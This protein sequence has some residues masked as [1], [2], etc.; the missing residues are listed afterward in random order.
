M[1]VEFRIRNFL[2]FKELQVL[3]LGRPDG[4]GGYDFRKTAFIYGANGS[5]KSNI[6]KA[7]D[8]SRRYIIGETEM[9]DYRF[10][11]DKGVVNTEPSYF[12]Y[13]IKLGD[14]VYSF[15]FE[16]DFHSYNIKSEWLYL[17]GE[18]DKC[19][20]EYEIDDTDDYA[21]YDT[22][23]NSKNKDRESQF[24]FIKNWFQEYMIVDANN[25]F[26]LCV[27]VTDNY[28]EDME[29]LLKSLDTGIT[30]I[31]KVAFKNKTIPYNL[32]WGMNLYKGNNL[33]RIEGNERKRDWL[34]FI[35]INGGK[36]EYSELCFKH[37]LEYLA[38]IDETS[39]GT[40]WIFH[41][42]TLFHSYGF[43]QDGLIVLDEIECSI[44]T[45][46]TQALVKLFKN[47]DDSV[48]MIATTHE[49]KLLEHELADV[50]DVWF[51]NKNRRESTLYSL[52]S[53]GDV[54][55]DYGKMYLDGRFYAV[56][57]LN[58]DTE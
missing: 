37:G 39:L 22:I 38:R 20:Y 7:L 45:M 17:L 40:Q 28:L 54:S 31:E 9:R 24:D 50:E 1:L 43:I 13:I 58:K 52:K 55:K 33:V 16:I 10:R 57:E 8:F 46:A 27:P 35:E 29:S 2:S 42:L 32:V 19:I 36:A 4:K 44:H 47:T 23:L 6:I 18:D 21:E 48:Q 49:W 12:E 41:L 5:G 11:N 3:R 26:N 56:P 34:L 15:G 14:D 53:F 51:V 25:S 30:K